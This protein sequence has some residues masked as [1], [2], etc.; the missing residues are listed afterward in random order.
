MY[1]SVVDVSK[2]KEKQQFANELR[3]WR[4]RL[5]LAYEFDWPDPCK[6]ICHREVNR[7]K[8]IVEGEDIIDKIMREK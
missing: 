6:F 7:L 3:E 2:F 5:A 4:K 8:E 1:V